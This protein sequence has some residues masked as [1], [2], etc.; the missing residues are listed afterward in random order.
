M[1]ILHSNDIFQV[2]IRSSIRL[3]HKV[4]ELS[5]EFMGVILRQAQLAQD[6]I[7]GAYPGDRCRQRAG[8]NLTP[9]VWKRY[10][11]WVPYDPEYRTCPQ[12]PVVE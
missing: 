10:I 7:C 11:S 1:C 2:V 8:R 9:A 6:H 5:G 3:V 4:D 12:W